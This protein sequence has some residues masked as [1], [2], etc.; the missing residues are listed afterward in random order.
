MVLFDCVP[1]TLVSAPNYDKEG[2][3]NETSVVP[4]ITNL[5]PNID[6]ACPVVGNS[7]DS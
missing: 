2:V 4:D 7:D 6:S 3:S 1:D 5:P